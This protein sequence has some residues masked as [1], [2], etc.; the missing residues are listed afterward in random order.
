MSGPLWGWAVC[1]RDSDRIE[2]ARSGGTVR[3]AS[4]LFGETEPHRRNEPLGVRTG[5]GRGHF[6]GS[7]GTSRFWSNPLAEGYRREVHLIFGCV[8]QLAVADPSGPAARTGNTRH[9]VVSD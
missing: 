1:L 9:V 6:G 4:V 5:D 3:Q 7:D 2:L 8:N